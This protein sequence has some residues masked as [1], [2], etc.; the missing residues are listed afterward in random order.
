[1]NINKNIVIVIVFGAVVIFATWWYISTQQIASQQ[2]M[3]ESHALLEQQSFVDIQT[4]EGDDE[5]E[6]LLALEEREKMMENEEGTSIKGGYKGYTSSKLS[7]A[8]EDGRVVLFFQ[9]RECSGC[10]VLD[11]NIRANLSQI[12]FDVL[13]LDVDSA[14]YADLKQE[15]GVTEPHTLVQVDEEGTMIA[16]WSGSTT[17]SDLLK[18]VR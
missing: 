16:K 8:Q 15:Y 2:I 3:T 10:R 11:A 14:Q 9:T 4:A 7:F 12:P 17:L 5:T 13:I 18:Q 1:M 6:T